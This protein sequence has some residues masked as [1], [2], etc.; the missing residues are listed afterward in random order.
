MCCGRYGRCDSWLFLRV[1]KGVYKFSWD[2][3]GGLRCV[4]MFCVVVLLWMILVVVVL[5]VRF[6]LVLMLLFFV[7]RCLIDVVR[8]LVMVLFIVCID[9]IYKFVVFGSCVE[10]YYCFFFVLFCL[11]FFV[12]W[13]YVYIFVVYSLN[14]WFLVLYILKVFI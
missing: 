8:M 9:G 2:W 11:F 14:F 13:I 7:W 12:W 6:Y 5:F 4:V 3:N 1:M 10:F